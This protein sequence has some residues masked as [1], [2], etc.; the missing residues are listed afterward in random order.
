[1]TQEKIKK[2][3]ELVQDEKF[4]KG[5][6]SL[7]GPSEIQQFL[8]KNGLC[9]TLD[10]VVELGEILKA[11]ID[12]MEE[13]IKGD[14]LSDDDLENVSGGIAVSTVLMIVSGVTTAVTAIIKNKDK[15]GNFF[16]KLFNIK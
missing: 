3:E 9:V 8:N 2:L 16:K 7:D 1:M 11:A 14:E 4:V 15:I 6:V 12:K 13:S 5:L 10:E